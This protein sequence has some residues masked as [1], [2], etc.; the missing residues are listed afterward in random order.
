MRRLSLVFPVLIILLACASNEIIPPPSDEI[1]IETQ[2]LADFEVTVLGNAPVASVQITNL[3][4]GAKSYSWVFGEGA[5]SAG[6]VDE[7]PK[8]LMVDKAGDFLIELTLVN[9]SAIKK[10][11][12]TVVIEGESAIDRFNEIEFSWDKDQPTSRS[13][14][15]SIIGRVLKLSDINETTGPLIDFVFQG[16]PATS[17]FF[18]S[19]DQLYNWN[20]VIPGALSAK[21]KNYQSIIDAYEFDS[22][23]GDGLLTTIDIEHDH[24]GVGADQFPKVVLF[25]NPEGK[26][27]AIKLSGYSEDEMMIAEIIIQ[28][29]PNPGISETHNEEQKFDP[30]KRK[31]LLRDEGKSQLSYV[32]LEDPTKDWHKSVPN[33]KGIQLV[34]DGKVMCGTPSGYEERDI[35]SGVKLAEVSGFPGTVSVRRLLNGN[36]ILAGLNW[37][38]GSGVVLVEVDQSEKVVRKIS[39]PQFSF[40]RTITETKL[41]TFLVASNNQVFEGDRLGNVRWSANI[42]GVEHAWGVIR[43]A[44]GNTVVSGGYAGNVQIVN[45]DGSILMAS[46]GPTEANPNFYAGFQIIDDASIIVANW[47]GHGS[48]NGNRGLQLVEYSLDGD[49]KWSWKQDAQCF[50]SIQGVIVLDGLNTG[51]Q[52]FEGPN[53]ALIEVD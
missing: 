8:T 40:V 48:G 35:A 18:D 25:Q 15:S 22:M 6:S 5:S 23:T 30:D 14:F 27:G 24:L 9:G 3:S 11:S 51:Y 49:H 39:Y 16:D 1:A 7:N 13:F 19:P 45:T 53:G 21:I 10:T 37:Q 42:V 50:S 17:Y 47:Q 33:G 34:G 43:L 44:N 29:Y 20:V 31:M 38:G 12:K 46:T 32:N 41:G 26:K 28:K 4:Q 52:Q 36:T 2:L